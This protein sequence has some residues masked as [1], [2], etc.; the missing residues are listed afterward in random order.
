M[1]HSLR[2]LRKSP[3]FSALVIGVLA[4]G[5]GANAALFSIIDRVLLHPFNYRDPDR[6][7]NSYQASGC[8]ETKPSNQRRR[9]GRR[10]K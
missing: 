6:L 3:G 7:P 9:G 1:R 5:M 4:L 2:S 10:R 8:Q